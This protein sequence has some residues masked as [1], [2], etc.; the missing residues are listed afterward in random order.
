[1]HGYF[2]RIF[3]RFI[4]VLVKIELIS[5]DFKLLQ[6]ILNWISSVLGRFNRVVFTFHC[7]SIC[8]CLLDFNVIGLLA[9]LIGSYWVLVSFAFAF[10]YALV[11]Y[12]RR[13]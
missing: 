9:I 11:T 7:A 4:Q 1:M 6:K 10:Q 2:K 3:T 5:L 8:R 12:T 13:P